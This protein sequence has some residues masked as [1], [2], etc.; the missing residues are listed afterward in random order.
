MAGSVCHTQPRGEHRS[1]C[2]CEQLGMSL[3]CSNRATF[4]SRQKFIAIRIQGLCEVY[5]IK[6]IRTT[7][8]QSDGMLE[9]YNRTLEEYLRTD[10]WFTI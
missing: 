6:K 3:R 2:F 1:K 7:P 9:W 8:L 4:R 5:A 10:P